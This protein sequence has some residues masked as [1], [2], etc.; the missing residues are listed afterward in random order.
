MMRRRSTKADSSFKGLRR[1]QAY[2]QLAKLAS[3][4][5]PMV[6]ALQLLRRNATDDGRRP[7][8][9][10]GLAYQAWADAL[11]RG[12]TLDR[13]VRG[14]VPDP[15][16]I[17]LGAGE[18][19]EQIPQAFQACADLEEAQMR[20]R[21]AL[22]AALV[23]PCFILLLTV[24]LFGF[25]SYMV[26]PKFA[27]L[28][29]PSQ[30]QGAAGYLP[31]VIDFLLGPGALFAVCV[32]GGALWVAFIALPRWHG[33]IR[34]VCDLF[35]P[36]SQ[37]RMWHGIYFL[38]SLSAMLRNGLAVID[39]LVSL[40]AGAQPWLRAELDG[41]LRNFRAGAQLGTSM[42]RSNPLFPSRSITREI[43][44]LE[45]LPGFYDDLEGFAWEY[46]NDSIEGIEKMGQALKNTFQLVNAGVLGWLVVA[47]MQL[48][49]QLQ[50][51]FT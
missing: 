33:P 36:F 22:V 16:R 5:I 38:L 8:D 42:T 43:S 24:M 37:Y 17:V 12:E 44:S 9:P 29:P 39:A 45:S 18:K 46:L 26:L 35:P 48:S 13:A 14:W 47:M 51:A 11:T 15:H 23:Y 41:I 49:Q 30:W 19:G 25:F 2:K 32:L 50:T 28:L 3:R 20:M 21:K 27:E 1:I 4:A 10:S 31:P 40:R 6:E 7:R 34:T